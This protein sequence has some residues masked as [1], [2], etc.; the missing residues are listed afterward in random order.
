MKAMHF[1]GS[2]FLLSLSVPAFALP[3]SQNPPAFKHWECVP[4]ARS[5]SG[6]QIRGDAHTWWGQADGRYRRG[7]EPRRGAVLAFKP[8]GAMTLGHVAAVS[9]VIDD[10]TILVTHSNWSP[11]N[12]VRGQIERDVRIIDVSERG[13]WSR[14]RVWYAPSGDLGTTEWPVH[15]FI[16]PEG[17]APMLLPSGGSEPVVKVETAGSAAVKPTGRLNYLGKT[18]SKLNK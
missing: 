5:L 11:I 1:A 3:L 8:H 17:K 13:D 15:G 7:N 12:G 4:I 14:V 10:R 6:I 2:L 9:K 18:L 16:Y